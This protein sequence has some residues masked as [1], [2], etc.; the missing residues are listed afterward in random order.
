[1]LEKQIEQRFR[2]RVIESG[3]L[4]MKFVSPGFA[5]VP[6]RIV[7]A[8]GG[9]VCFV[10]LKRPGG[11]VRPLQARAFERMRAYG[12]KVFVVDSEA[13]IE[14]FIGEAFADD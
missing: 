14:E 13:A 3:G 11:K 6:D 9:R 1:M 10:E 4:S 7:L 12:V 8:P 5:G 2:R